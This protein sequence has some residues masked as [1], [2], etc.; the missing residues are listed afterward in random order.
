MAARRLRPHG[1][2][3]LT[4]ARSLLMVDRVYAETR[5]TLLLSEQLLDA[6]SSFDWGAI[7]VSG[8][9][10]KPT[11]DSRTC[12]KSG[13][14]LIHFLANP[15]FCKLRIYQDSVSTLCDF[16]GNPVVHKMQSHRTRVWQTIDIDE[17]S[18]TD[19]AGLVEVALPGLSAMGFRRVNT[20]TR[21]LRRPT[22]PPMR[23]R[24]KCACTNR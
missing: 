19:P 7:R 20:K 5:K 24:S 18:K 12:S 14:L 9:E 23:Q 6:C 15:C 8:R 10:L 17:S 3:K 1:L 11:S 13:K 4:Y 22:R 21:N 2:G 16:F